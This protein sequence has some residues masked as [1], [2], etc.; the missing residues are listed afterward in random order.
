MTIETNPFSTYTNSSE[1]I[2]AWWLNA[3]RFG[4]TLPVARNFVQMTGSQMFGN[5]AGTC[6]ARSV[7][8]ASSCQMVHLRVMRCRRQRPDTDWPQEGER[9]GTDRNICKWS[10]KALNRKDLLR[11]LRVSARCSHSVA[12]KATVGM[13]PYA[14]TAYHDHSSRT[15]KQGKAADG[16]NHVNSTPSA[17]EMDHECSL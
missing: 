11:S 7:N 16:P 12:C 1:L 9:G 13:R 14:G 17:H 5:M 8:V 6:E 3:A 15:R 2:S 4:Q 10:R